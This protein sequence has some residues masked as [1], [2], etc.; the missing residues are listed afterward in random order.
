MGGKKTVWAAG[1]LAYA[2]CLVYAFRSA[3]AEPVIELHE[4]DWS[5]YEEGLSRRSFRSLPHF[6]HH[7]GE[8]LRTQVAVAEIY[9]GRALPPAFRER[10]M[11]VTAYANRC[12]W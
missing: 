11:L 7:L 10:I 9:L 3:R 2:A 1:Y 6:L 5:V 8:L 4:C 12:G